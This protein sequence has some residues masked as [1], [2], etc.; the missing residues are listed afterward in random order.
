M[1]FF[2]KSLAKNASKKHFVFLCNTHSIS[3]SI[4]LICWNN[5]T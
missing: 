5:K 2:Q 3:L 4:F 1:V